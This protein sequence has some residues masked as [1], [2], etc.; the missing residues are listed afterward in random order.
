MF[1]AVWK[2][3]VMLGRTSPSATELEEVTL[4]WLRQMIG[5]PA[6]FGGVVYDTASIA[7]LCAIAAARQAVPGLRV[8]IDGLSNAVAHGAPIDPDP[9]S[10][11]RLRMYTSEQA[12]SSVEKAA[13]I[14]GIGQ[15]GVR[16]IPTD[17]EYRMDPAALAQT[18][19]EDRASGWTPFCVVATVGTT[20]TTSIDPV[21]QIADIC[22]KEKVWLHVDASY[23]GSAAVLPEMRW[24][25]SGCDRADSLVLNPHKWLFVP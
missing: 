23:G 1:W 10:A 3:N 12:H 11:K 18:I 14:L 19:C 9:G 4:D 16:K 13:I 22:E 5:L 8:R 17:R 7:T 21:P 2:V 24:I 20:S 25:L 15:A 6:G